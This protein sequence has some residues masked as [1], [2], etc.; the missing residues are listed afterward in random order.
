LVLQVARCPSGRQDWEVADWIRNVIDSLGP[1]GVG[2][3]IALETII[4]PIPSEL[5]LPLA[6]FRAREGS[7]NVI[8]VWI[9]ATI[10]GVAAALL[11]YWLGA[12]LGYERLHRL[13]GHKWFFIASQKDVDRGCALFERH[14][15]WIV[16]GSRCV[17]V[18]RS[19]VSLPAGMTRMP[20]PK[21]L[22][23][24]ALG[25][26]VW[27]AAFIAAGWFMAEKWQKVDAYMGP[28]SFV[29]IGLIVIGLV[30]T[31]WRRRHE[32]SAAR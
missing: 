30:I 16:A 19:L 13:A 32:K 22:A 26:G 3:L 28:I 23:L 27:N 29:V 7:M 25:T 21:F 2:A 31:A 14:G 24:T 12:W 4:P 20:L 6:G 9:A 15:S 5:V 1:F 8:L 18:L 17:P 11:L 10:G